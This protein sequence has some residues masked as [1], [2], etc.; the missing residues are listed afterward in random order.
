MKKAGIFE[1]KNKTTEGHKSSSTIFAG[2]L[3]GRG[4][5]G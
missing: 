5:R 3:G 4:V 1:S 2:R